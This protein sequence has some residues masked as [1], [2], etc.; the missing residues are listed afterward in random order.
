M[1]MSIWHPSLI[2]NAF[3]HLV[4]SLLGHNFPHLVPSLLGHTFPHLC[5]YLSSILS[6]GQHLYSSAALSYG[7]HLYSSTVLFLGHAFPHPPH[8]FLGHTFS[9]PPPS[10]YLNTIYLHYATTTL[11]ILCTL[12]TLPVPSINNELCFNLKLPPNHDLALDLDPN[13]IEQGRE[14]LVK[15]GLEEGE[16]LFI[17]DLMEGKTHNTTKEQNKPV[18]SLVFR[19]SP[20][21]IM[22]TPPPTSLIQDPIEVFFLHPLLDKDQSV[23]PD[24]SSSSTDSIHL[25]VPPNSKTILSDEVESMPS[26]VPSVP[27]KSN[28]SMSPPYMSHANGGTSPIIDTKYNDYHS[29][30]IPNIMQAIESLC[31]CQDEIIMNDWN[32]HMFQDRSYFGHPIISGGAKLPTE[33]PQSEQT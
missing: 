27:F 11:S 3:T 17:Q 18:K 4:F 33:G 7:P 32:P 24:F 16:L 31:F 28:K 20:T 12:P 23:Y 8:F 14:S 15:L 22:L 10:L 19:S 2:A 6:F 25:A 13:P 1:P 9:H 30:Y 29:V 21:S 26:L 5:L